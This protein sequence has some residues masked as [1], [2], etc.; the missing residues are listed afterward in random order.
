MSTQ[1]IKIFPL[2]KRYN[3]LVYF[4]F[5]NT[6]LFIIISIRY[7]QFMPFPSTLL[8]YF[9][10]FFAIIGQMSLL[11]LGISLFLALFLIIPHTTLRNN[12]IALFAALTTEYLISDTFAFALYKQHIINLSYQDI[13]TIPIPL[14]VILL[15]STCILFIVYFFLL[16]WIE[17]NVQ[18]TRF[19][20][21]FLTIIIFSFL[22][23]H[24]LHIWAAS[25][26]YKPITN[27][28]EF[29]PFYTPTTANKLIR[30]LTKKKD[31]S[32]P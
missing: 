2:R 8:T 13:L 6:L 7:L 28:T 16:T 31:I 11:S 29:I 9:Y 10:L 5:I 26:A 19:I 14:F 22:L 18:Q 21:S 30:S 25:V 1:Q 17:K 27:T 12:I 4:T 15:S 3:T 32:S 24:G 23:S 20:K